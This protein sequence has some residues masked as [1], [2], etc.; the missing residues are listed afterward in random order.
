MSTKNVFAII[1]L[2]EQNLYYTM[3]L[4]PF[5]TFGGHTHTVEE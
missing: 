4:K 2:S 3:S 5:R 1:S